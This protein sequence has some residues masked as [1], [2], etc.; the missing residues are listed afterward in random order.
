MQEP[1]VRR[2]RPDE[3]EIV[4]AI[5]ASTFSE[6]FGHLYSREDLTAFMAEAYSLARTQADLNDPAK[7]SWLVEAD[8]QV[9][10]YALTG[11]CG[12]P[13]PEVTTACGELKRIYLSKPWQNGGLGRRLFSEA[14]DWLLRDG[15]RDLWIGVWSENHGAQR[16]YE[17]HGFVRVGEY[18]FQVG[19]T[20]DREFILRRPAHGSTS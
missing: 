10:G 15:P 13:H 16:F 1:I 3:V 20:T 19:S 18:G 4:A 14:I 6:T 12:L 17:R 7:A 8:G 5:G 9:V 2:A 11:P